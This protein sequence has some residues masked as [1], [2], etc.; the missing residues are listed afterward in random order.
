MDSLYSH[1]NIYVFTYACEY[2]SNMLLDGKSV[3]KGHIFSHHVN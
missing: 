3:T 2:D 1:I